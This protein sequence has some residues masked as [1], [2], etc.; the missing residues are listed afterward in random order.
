MRSLNTAELILD[1]G[2]YPRHSIDS[3]HVSYM[4]ESI[5]AGVALPP[6][7]ID[8]KSKRV[9]DGFHRVTAFQHLMDRLKALAELIDGL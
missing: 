1:Y 3:Q 2:L 4:V 8:K 5:R 6:V 7:V 9:V